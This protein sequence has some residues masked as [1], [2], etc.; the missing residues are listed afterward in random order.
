MFCWEFGGACGGQNIYSHL[1]MLRENFFLFLLA[2][3]LAE[4]GQPR[5][6]FL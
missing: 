4:I 2:R 1:G 5:D 3:R 6:L